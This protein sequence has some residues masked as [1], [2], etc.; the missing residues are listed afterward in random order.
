MKIDGIEV[1]QATARCFP[2]VGGGYAIKVRLQDQPRHDETREMV[3]G[4][5]RTEKFAASVVRKIK[6]AETDLTSIELLAMYKATL[7]LGDERIAFVEKVES[8]KEAIKKLA[9]LV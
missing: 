5:V 2:A 1:R 3:L 6:E 9:A 4:P 7:D 8:P